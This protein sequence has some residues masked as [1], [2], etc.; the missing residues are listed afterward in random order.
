M[1]QT[2][3]IAQRLAQMT[4]LFV[5]ILMIDCASGI[6]KSVAYLK[7]RGADLSDIATATVVLN[8]YGGKMYAGPLGLGLHKE[9]IFLTRECVMEGE[10]CSSGNIPIPKYIPAIDLGNRNGPS[11]WSN[12]G[13]TVGLTYLEDSSVILGMDRAKSLHVNWISKNKPGLERPPSQL[14]RVGFTAGFLVGARFEFNPGELLDFVVGMVGF[15]LY[16]DDRFVATI[17]EETLAMIE[18]GRYAEFRKCLETK[19]ID[20]SQKTEAGNNLLHHA[21]RVARVS[22]MRL[23]VESYGFDIN[24]VNDLGWTPM[25]QIGWCDGVT[26]SEAMYGRCLES[27]EYLESKGG[28]Y[29]EAGS[30]HFHPAEIVRAVQ[31]EDLAVL[32]TYLNSKNPTNRFRTNNENQKTICLR[33]AKCG[34]IQHIDQIKSNPEEVDESGNVTGYSARWGGLTLLQL[35]IVYDRRKVV[36]YLLERGADPARKTFRGYDSMRISRDLGRTELSKLLQ[37]RTMP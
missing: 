2:S 7:N 9:G 16:H 35:A 14:T 27:I 21:A 17:P 23:L 36:I 34:V 20:L 25:G 12:L 29:L 19:C 1:R 13:E 3:T 8:A 5:L 32:E 30:M 4:G 33:E 11:A 31:Q 28:S 15:D 37:L 18:E 6:S 26:A 22:I 24:A 10:H